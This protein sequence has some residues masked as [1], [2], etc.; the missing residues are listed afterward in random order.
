MNHGEGVGFG[1]DDSRLLVVFSSSRFRFS[2]T[3][4][5]SSEAGIGSTGAEV[6]SDGIWDVGVSAAA[7]GS[8]S[9][10]DD[11]VIG[12]GGLFRRQ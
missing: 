5:T 9:T 8:S 10:E 11:D 7:E 6:I 12:S 3:A 1:S 2:P 4:S